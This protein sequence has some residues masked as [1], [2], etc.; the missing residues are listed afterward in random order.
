MKDECERTLQ[1]AYLFLD[2]EVLSEGER[3][4]IQR[5]LEACR[6]CYERYGLAHEVSALVARLRNCQRC[7]EEVRLRII[8]LFR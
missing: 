5:H 2:Q 6:P 1:R 4:E 7:P 3:V 8:A